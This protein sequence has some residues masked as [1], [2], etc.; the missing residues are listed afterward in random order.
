MT[1]AS[2]DLFLFAVLPYLAA[3]ACVLESVRRYV[4]EPFTYSSLSSQ[5]LEN[6]HQFWGSVPFHYGLLV[7]LGGHL[8]AFAAPSGVL[9]WNAVPLRL[10][11]LETTG[12]VFALLALMGL[13]NLV[14]RR[15]TEGSVRV[16]T[17]RADW[18]LLGLL[19][20]QLALGA[21]I[22]LFKPW[23][24]SWYAASMV[25]YLRSVLALA[26]DLAFVA[27]MPWVVKAH[28]VGAYLLLAV[29]PYTRLAHFLVLPVHYLWRAPQVVRWA[30]PR[31]A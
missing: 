2:V 22:A 24:S 1:G 7:V 31:K 8:A 12:F 25:P 30:R 14:A 20:A 21:S 23:G 16:V 4:R 26:P 11:L 29:V 17:T 19:G 18:A 9:L 13:A 6:R 28:V 27:P 10:Y 5:F 15:L 3:A